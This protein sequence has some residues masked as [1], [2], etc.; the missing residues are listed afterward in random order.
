[1][2]ALEEGGAAALATPRPLGRETRNS[3]GIRV[4]D[5]PV[6]RSARVQ[7]IEVLMAAA[8]AGLPS[9]GGSSAASTAGS[10]TPGQG[11]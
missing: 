3:N 4:G 9:F 11:A 2:P 5:A 1:M 8:V 7:A 10:F 6:P